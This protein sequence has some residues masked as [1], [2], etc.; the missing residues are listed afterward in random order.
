MDDS[1]LSIVGSLQVLLPDCPL[2]DNIH[3]FTTLR[4]GGCSQPPYH[5]LNLGLHV[6]DSAAAV[7]A[8]RKTLVDALQLPAIPVWLN[9]THGIDVCTSGRPTPEQSHDAAWSAEAGRVLAVLT[10]DC[11]PVVLSAIDGSEI[12]VAHAGWRGLADG[13]LQNTVRQFSHNG[14][15]LQAWLGPAIGPEKFEVGAEVR[16][17]FRSKMRDPTTVDT[18][19]VAGHTATPSAG[20]WYADLYQLARIA[21][22]EAGV[23]TVYGGGQCTYQDS[24]HY[25]SYRR[26]GVRSGRMATLIWRS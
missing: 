8:N 4:A 18:A 25:F 7:T 13:V 19:F 9:Q 1:R 15:Q 2:P 17:L 6:G 23:G 14:T 26:D 16:A 5:S 22:F 20:K 24:Q 3:I 10:A 11:L 21:L 12:A